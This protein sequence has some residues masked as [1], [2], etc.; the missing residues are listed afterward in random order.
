MSPLI[1]PAWI[2][3]EA[4]CMRASS[5]IRFLAENVPPMECITAKAGSSTEISAA[6][7]VVDDSSDSSSVCSCRKGVF[8]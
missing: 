7:R 5:Q 2:E 1:S 8:V 4:S 3:Y 6:L